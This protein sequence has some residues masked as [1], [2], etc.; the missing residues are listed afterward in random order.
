MLAQANFS[1]PF[2]ENTIIDLPIAEMSP[3]KIIIEY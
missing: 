1:K 3:S 2:F